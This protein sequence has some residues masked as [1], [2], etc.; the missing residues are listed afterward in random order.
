MRP[1]R[2]YSPCITILDDESASLASA[3]ESSQS[4]RFSCYPS[5]IGPLHNRASN[6]SEKISDAFRIDADSVLWTR[7]DSPHRVEVFALPSDTHRKNVNTTI[8]ER[9][10]TQ[11]GGG[12]G[13]VLAGVLA[14]AQKD[15]NR[16]RGQLLL[17]V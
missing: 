1:V 8:L 4:A 17:V 13:D 9:N 2:P 7:C 12:G 16:I 14:V 6:L 10:R 5:D 15:A 3:S 11:K